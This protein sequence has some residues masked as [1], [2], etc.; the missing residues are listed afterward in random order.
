MH[1]GVDGDNFECTAL[2][3]QEPKTEVTRYHIEENQ[4]VW[5]KETNCLGGIDHTM[6]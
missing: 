1:M 6:P 4:H 5:K 3:F 2:R